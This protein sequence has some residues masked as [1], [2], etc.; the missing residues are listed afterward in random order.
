LGRQLSEVEAAELKRMVPGQK[1]LD[2]EYCRHVISCSG[3]G[4]GAF[5]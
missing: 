5:A 2:G 4:G 1:H 3:I